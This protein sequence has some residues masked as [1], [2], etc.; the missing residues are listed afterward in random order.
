MTM[1][2]GGLPIYILRKIICVKFLKLK[3]HVSG[4]IKSKSDAKKEEDTTIFTV[5][6][7]VIKAEIDHMNL[8]PL[9]E[10]CK[11]TR[12][13]QKLH[14]FSMRYNQQM[15]EDEAKKVEVKKK[16]SLEAFLKNISKKKKVE[17]EVTVQPV[18]EEKPVAQ[19]CI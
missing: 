18:V 9:I 11:A 13:A 1:I 17:E 14:G 3:I 12:L 5:E 7:F 6:D 2:Y 19:V 10:F 16:S 15:L 8:R 4:I